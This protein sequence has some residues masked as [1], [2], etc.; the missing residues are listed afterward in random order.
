MRYSDLILGGII[1]AQ[2]VI[3]HIERR[4][5]YNRIMS[6]DIGEYRSGEFKQRPRETRHEKVMR[7]WRK[8]REDDR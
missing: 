8:R 6:R 1:I 4:D 5:L 2:A 7:L 3:Y